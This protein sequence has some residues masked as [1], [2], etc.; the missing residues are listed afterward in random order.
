[1]PHSYRS[2]DSLHFFDSP[3]IFQS[4]S[5]FHYMFHSVKWNKT[6]CTFRIQGS[7][8]VNPPWLLHSPNTSLD[9]KSP[10]WVWI[11]SNSSLLHFIITILLKSQGFVNPGSS[12]K[13]VPQG[14][15][16]KGSSNSHIVRGSK[17]GVSSQFSA[18]TATKLDW[19]NPPQLMCG[20][21]GEGSRLLH[22][23]INILL[24]LEKV[25]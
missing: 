14:D 4:S 2:T 13:F 15:T 21:M 7:I 24:S 5:S 1:M 8:W 20:E 6:G 19:L 11:V 25:L 9:W 22:G 17:I 12:W 23:S 3:P 16:T 10:P 18:I